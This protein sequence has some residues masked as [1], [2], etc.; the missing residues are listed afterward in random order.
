MS[1]TLNCKVDGCSG[2][3]K[4]L[5]NGGVGFFRGYCRKHYNILYNTGVIQVTKNRKY[6]KHGM[7]SHPLYSTWCGMIQRCTYEKH[8]DFHRYGGRGIKVCKRWLDSFHLFVEDMG[9]KPAGTTLDRVDP[10]GNYEKSNCRWADNHTQAKN[11]KHRDNRTGYKYI[12]LLPSGNYH[13][14][15]HVNQARI[16]VGTFPTIEE[17]VMNRDKALSQHTL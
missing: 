17:A 1:I 7:S 14:V 13:V 15:V 5:K 8:K 9:E 2:I 6:E 12:S 10:D 16:L 11:R 4:R 3:G